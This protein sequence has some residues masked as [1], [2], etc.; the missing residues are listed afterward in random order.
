MSKI[1][2]SREEA[3]QSPDSEEEEGEWLLM[4]TV[5]WKAEEGVVM[6]MFWN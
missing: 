2:R 6:K 1:G 3:E 4:F 5:F